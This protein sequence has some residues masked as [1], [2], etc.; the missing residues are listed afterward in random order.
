MAILSIACT[1][2]I[3]FYLV[4]TLGMGYATMCRNLSILQR[5]KFRKSLM[6][7]NR[8]M[9]FLLNAHQQK[10]LWSRLILHMYFVQKNYFIGGMVYHGV[11]TLTC[12][13]MKDDPIQMTNRLISTV[14][15]TS[16]NQKQLGQYKIND[17]FPT[18]YL[19]IHSGRNIDAG[20][21]LYLIYGVCLGLLKGT[22]ELNKWYCATHGFIFPLIKEIKSLNNWVF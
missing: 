15:S 8:T 12:M 9:S 1:R 22:S 18:F 5:L 7:L 21:L 13:F 4:K 3:I 19:F 10:E 16:D 14:G 11:C 2:I 6:T 20:C 17:Q